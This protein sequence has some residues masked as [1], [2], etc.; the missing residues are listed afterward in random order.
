MSKIDRWLVG[1][2]TTG[3]GVL[4]AVTLFAPKPLLAIG[5]DAREV[6]GLASFD[7]SL[8]ERHCRLGEGSTRIR[9]QTQ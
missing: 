9:C 7:R 6:L 1:V 5:V 3:V 8:V 4:I 2:M